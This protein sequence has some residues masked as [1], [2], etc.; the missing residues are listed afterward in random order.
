MQKDKKK[1]FRQNTAQHRQPQRR[2][3]AQSH[4]SFREEVFRSQAPI[5]PLLQAVRK[6]KNHQVMK[7]K[8]S[9]QIVD[10]TYAAGTHSFDCPICGQNFDVDGD[11]V[12]CKMRIHQH[13]HMEEGL[14]K[15]TATEV[16]SKR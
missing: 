3:L 2:Y 8:Y 5:R 9:D 12:A 11:I 10:V 13:L 15:D 4:D 6:V 1:I 14:E 16:E 7:L